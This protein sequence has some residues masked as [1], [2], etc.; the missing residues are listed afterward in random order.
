MMYLVFTSLSMPGAVATTATI[1]YRGLIF[2]IPLAVGLYIY[3]Q[4]KIKDIFATK[5]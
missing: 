3:Q 4:Q 2:W 1:I 5:I